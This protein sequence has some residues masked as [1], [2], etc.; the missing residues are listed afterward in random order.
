MSIK[1][2]LKIT[3]YLKD[4]LSKNDKTSDYMFIPFSDIAESLKYNISTISQN[5]SDILD[6]LCMSFYDYYSIE[7]TGHCIIIVF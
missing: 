1:E 7:S 3:E 6:E 5:I 4:R 2:I